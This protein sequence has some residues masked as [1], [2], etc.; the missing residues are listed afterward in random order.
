MCALNALR[1]VRTGGT[2]RGGA[3]GFKLDTV[4]KLRE[5]KSVSDRNMTFLHY[6]VDLVCVCVG[7]RVRVL[8][9][10]GCGPGV[11]CLYCRCQPS[12]N[13]ALDGRTSCPMWVPRR[14]CRIG[15]CV[16]VCVCM[17]RDRHVVVFPVPSSTTIFA[18]WTWVSRTFIRL[19]GR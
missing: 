9:S 16:C 3:Y 18:A 13:R 7:T 1:D 8:P 10:Y 12:L 5:T 6:L 14:G 11:T 2:F 4:N 19:F 17:C 15:V